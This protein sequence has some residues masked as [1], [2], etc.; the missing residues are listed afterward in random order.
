MNPVETRYSAFDRELLAVYAT[1]R[2][3]R[4]N[5]EGRN[6]IVNTDHKP[7]TFVMSSVTERPSLRQSRQLAF[8]AEFTTDIRY[9][10]GE[11]NFVADAL[12]RP[13]VSA[14]DNTSAINYKELSADQALDAEFTRL[15]HSTS[16][17]MNFKLLKSFDNHLIWCDVSTGHNRPYLTERFRKTVFLNLY[18]LG[19]PS[20]RATKPLI[21]TRFVWHGMN[22]DIAKWCRSCKGCQTAKISRHNQPV[23]GK[24]TEPTERFDH[25]HIDIVGPLPYAD[26]FRYL[27]T[28]VDR[29]T[30]WPE[31]IPIVDIRAETVA[32]AFF[33]EW[34]ARFGTP[35]TITTD[36]GAQFESKLW[37]GLCNQFGIVRNRTTSYNPQ[38]SGMVERFHR[39]LKAAIMAHESPN[40][41]TITLP[42]I[43]LG[44]RSAVK[45]LLGRSAA[46]MIYGTTL[47]LPREFTEKYTVYAHTNL[48]NY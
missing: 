34:I 18:G 21:N 33:S 29:F 13:S 26:G 8:K 45:E 20:Q 42:S 2:H 14:I 11:T 41:W 30:R 19:H 39:Q 15:R 47:R 10:K 4:H 17:T 5:L 1:I 6:F 25:V 35:A 22:I 23:F 36:R 12:S 3:F 9:V 32:D 46:E 48:D 28:C 38:S 40:P 37:D 44:V 43:L 27:L 31:A 24:F 7:L 16:S